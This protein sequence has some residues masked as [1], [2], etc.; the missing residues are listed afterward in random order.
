MHGRRSGSPELVTASGPRRHFGSASL[1]GCII[2]AERSRAGCRRP[3]SLERRPAT[4]DVVRG[5]RAEKRI[6]SFASHYHA[7]RF[8]IVRARHAAAAA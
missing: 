1:A 7:M 5:V 4:A 2:R 8:D 6:A 3:I